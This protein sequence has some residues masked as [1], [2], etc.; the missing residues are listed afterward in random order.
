MKHRLDLE[1]AFGV[2]V[3]AAGMIG[4]LAESLIKRECRRKDA[5]QVV[6]GFGGV[7]DV[8]DA[9]IFAAPLSYLLDAGVTGGGGTSVAGA[10][11]SRMR[12]G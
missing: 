12:P 3:G 11:G 4:D 2:S 8:L 10:P 9:V 1:I 5:S 7:L 6:P